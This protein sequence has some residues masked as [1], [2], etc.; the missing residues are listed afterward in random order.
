MTGSVGF[1]SSIPN[2]GKSTIAAAMAHLVAMSGASCLLIDCDL[3]NPTLSNRLTPTADV[4]LIEVLSGSYSL[5]EAVWKDASGFDFLPAVLR[6]RLANTSDILASNAMR[7]LFEDVRESYQYVLVDL[8]PVSPVI[9][10]R[11][12]SNL[13]GAYVYVVEWGAT[14]PDVVR[15]ALKNA[16]ELCENL[17]GIVLNK[18]DLRTLRNYGQTYADYHSNKYAERYGLSGGSSH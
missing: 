4:G 14:K 15:Y 18:V 16:P 8:S 17:V 11:A 10:V 3:R 9:D 2:E 6:S 13:V 5:A 12:T 7:R 1:T